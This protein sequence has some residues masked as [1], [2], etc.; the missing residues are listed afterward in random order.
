M[1]PLLVLKS[2]H[3]SAG[4]WR[5]GECGESSDRCEEGECRGEKLEAEE[6][7]EDGR[8]DCNPAACQPAVQ[9]CADDEG[10]V[11]GA[12]GEGEEGDEDDAGGEAGDGDGM[13]PAAIAN[14]SS[15]HPACPTNKVKKL[16]FQEETDQP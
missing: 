11:G 6:A 2:V 3:K 13:E 15:H 4:Q 9:T 16:G 10:R 14:P 5:S 8:H 12:V 1:R 7:D